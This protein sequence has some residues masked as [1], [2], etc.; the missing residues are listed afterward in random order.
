MMGGNYARMLKVFAVIFALNLLSG[1]ANKADSGVQIPKERVA[2]V[3][4][5]DLTAKLPR[6]ATNVWL[7]E[8]RFQD[9]IQLVRFDASLDEAREFSRNVL[10]QAALPGFDP[11]FEYLGH[12]RRWWLSSFPLGAEGGES[13]VEDTRIRLVL[14]PNRGRARVWLAINST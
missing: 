6:S 4:L 14:R 3:D 10:G 7:Y 5:V 12:N 2:S 1:C 11:H 8:A 13:T 9:G